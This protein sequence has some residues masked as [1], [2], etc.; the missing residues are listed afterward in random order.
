MAA[1][2]TMSL[3]RATAVSAT[4]AALLGIAVVAPL[5]RMPQLITGT[6]VNADL[7][8]AVVLIGPRAAVGVAALPSLFAVAS[9]QLP[10]PLAPLLPVIVLGNLL[11]VGLFGRLRQKS[12]WLGVVVA[13][14]VKFA[15]LFGATS[16]L[17]T[18]THLLAAPAV[19][20]ALVMMGWPQLTT[21]LAGGVVAYAVLDPAG[22]RP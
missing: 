6:I 13:A 22:S 17:A 15:W 19:P 4:F 12:W 8:A 9:G 7:L 1:T 20:V 14:V 5:L 21:A 3:Q 11:L 2:R 10:S 16:L 18:A